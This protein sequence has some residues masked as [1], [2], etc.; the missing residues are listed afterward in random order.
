MKSFNTTEELVEYVC[1]TSTTSNY[2]EVCPFPYINKGWDSIIKWRGTNFDGASEVEAN[3]C[4]ITYGDSLVHFGMFEESCVYMTVNLVCALFCFH[5]LKVLG[6]ERKRKAKGARGRRGESG[7]GWLKES[8]ITEKVCLGNGLISLCH[9][10]AWL[11]FDGIMV[12]GGGGEE[13]GG[14]ERSD[15][16]KVVGAMRAWEGGGANETSMGRR[17]SYMDMGDA[18]A[19]NSLSSSLLRS[20]LGCPALCGALRHESGVRCGFYAHLC[21]T[22]YTVDLDHGDRRPCEEEERCHQ[23]DSMALC[24]CR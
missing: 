17:F 11:D 4:S 5:L 7:E 12:R 14:G 1:R 3:D 19:A 18:T 22:D 24:V 13:G 16:L 21:G 20:S 23:V 10:V 6:N 9:G 15:E 2:E 8:T